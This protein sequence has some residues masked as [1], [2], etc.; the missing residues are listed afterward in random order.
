MADRVSV[1]LTLGGAITADQ[2]QELTALIRLEGLSI[3]WDGAPFEP[4]DHTEGEPL[5]LFAHEV[6]WGRVEQ[7]ETW[8]VDNRVPF[9]RW[10]GGYAGS[11]GPERVVYPGA[12]GPAPFVADEE[13]RILV[14][15]ETVERLGS[16]EALLGHFDAADL[17]IPPLVVNGHP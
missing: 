17:A 3:E 12:G 16:V 6:A 14:D 9:A 1:A 15:R 13:D 4:H 11:W 8:C 7:I 10:S 2:Y 5:R